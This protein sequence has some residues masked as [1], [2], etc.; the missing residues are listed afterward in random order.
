MSVWVV[1]L[2]AGVDGPVLW[3]NRDAGHAFWTAED[4]SSYGHE[5]ISKL[6]PKALPIPMAQVYVPSVRHDT[7]P[8]E[9]CRQSFEQFVF[10]AAWEAH[11]Q[12][13]RMI[14]EAVVVPVELEEF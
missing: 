11:Q 14:A 4:A 10:D 13:C 9:D 3:D 7:L 5:Q 8:F 6:V 2:R 12:A 1:E